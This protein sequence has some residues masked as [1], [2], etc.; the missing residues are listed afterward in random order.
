ME[1]LR[2]LGE[3][4]AGRREGGKEGRKGIGLSLGMAEG[5]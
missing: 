3:R 1:S 2:E 5:K 4:L